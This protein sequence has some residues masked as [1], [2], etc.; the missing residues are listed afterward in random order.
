MGI[1]QRTGDLLKPRSSQ[2]PKG[3][4]D[5]K[6]MKDANRAKRAEAV[7]QALEFHPMA[8]VILVAGFHKTVDLFQVDGQ[9]NPKLQSVHIQDFPI[10]TAHFSQDGT[11]VVMASRKKRFIVYDMMAG[12]VKPVY[13][14]RGTYSY[15]D[16]IKCSN[17]SVKWK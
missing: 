16:L 13:G 5:L 7:V 11:E 3:T 4:L 6:R 14:I 1:L 8:N 15:K 12:K 17:W 10:T 2:L 9:R